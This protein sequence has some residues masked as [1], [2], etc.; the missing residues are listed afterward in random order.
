MDRASPTGVLGRHRRHTCLSRLAD[1]LPDGHFV[2]TD[3]ATGLTEE[4]A[5]RVC[6]ALCAQQRRAI[7]IARVPRGA[8][9]AGV[10]A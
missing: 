2:Q 9:A 10:S 7:G 5:E 3:P 6:A 8:G 1:E 4:D